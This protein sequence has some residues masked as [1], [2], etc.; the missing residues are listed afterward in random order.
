MSIEAQNN[1]DNENL[2]QLNSKEEELKSKTINE[3]KNL[4]KKLLSSSISTILVKLESNSKTQMNSL[5]ETSKTFK[6]FDKNLNY[7]SKNLAEYLKKKE[8]EKEKE[9]EKRKKF[10][11]KSSKKA[12]Q[13]T[14]SNRSKTKD[15]TL[16]TSFTK[17]NLSTTHPN[18]HKSKKNLSVASTVLNTSKTLQQFKRYAT[19]TNTNFKKERK[20]FK[21][22][23]PKRSGNNLRDKKTD[24]RE[25]KKINLIDISEKIEK[26]SNNKSKD[27]QIE[28]IVKL[29]DDVN[30]NLNKI[31]STESNNKKLSNRDYNNNEQI[32]NISNLNNK[33]SLNNN[34][35]FNKGISEKELPS[36]NKKIQNSKSDYKKDMNESIKNNEYTKKYNGR[37]SKEVKM[38]YRDKSYDKD[39]Y[40]SSNKMNNKSKNNTCV[41]DLNKNIKNVKGKLNLSLNNNSKIENSEV[42]KDSNK[43][44]KIRNYSHYKKENR[45]QEKI[46]NIDKKFSSK[47]EKSKKLFNDILRTNNNKV[48]SLILQ[49]LNKNDLLLFTSTNKI[50]NNYRVKFLVS[51]RKELN[52]LLDLKDNETIEQ[53]V[54]FLKDK[55]W[56]ENY[57]ENKKF[58][59]SENLVTKI[60][61]LNGEK[62]FK[63]FLDNKFID[64]D[65]VF[66]D[67][68]III[69]RLLYII[70]D[71]NGNLN[72]I[73]NDKTFSKYFFKF[74]VKQC[75]NRKIGD[76]IIEKINKFN[77]D[78]KE[79][80][81]MEKI[82]FANKSEIINNKYNNICEN[83]AIFAELIREVLIYAGIIVVDNQT[84]GRRI[85]DNVEYEQK[86]INNLTEFILRY[87][88]FK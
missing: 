71:N 58:D 42:N 80:I 3:A 43:Q 35:N 27:F 74:V 86:L 12:T 18:F 46:K 1:P 14:L 36:L 22:P 47:N 19:L 87:S 16:K 54:K 39:I 59:I 20:E 57:N 76:Y 32:N 38:K 25:E 55:Y 66:F 62:Y 17:N 44:K 78:H 7:Y 11:K 82:A 56:N 8:K 4:L 30:Q 29:V 21:S 37:N 61:I 63:L 23:S 69:Y 40:N 83:T 34:A 81:K 53:K 9:K 65:N 48:I 26:I 5:K 51:K 50:F 77:F 52:L 13:Q 6:Q 60:K 88:I 67:M 24:F 84:Q 33:D 73:K 70:L 10:S 64:I 45:I 72:E 79:I 75:S 85:I 41:I 2:S 49:F 15:S 31:L 28:N 68:I